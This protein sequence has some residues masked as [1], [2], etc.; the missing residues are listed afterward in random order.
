[1]AESLLVL[2]GS[3]PPRRRGRPAPL[4]NVVRA[5]LAEVEDFGRID[6]LSFDEVMVAS[7]AAADLAH[8]LSELMENA[9]NF[10]PPESRIEVVGHRTKADGYV[11][12]VTDHGIGMSGDQIASANESLAKPPLVGLAMTRSLGFIVVG[13]LA[14]RHGIAVRMMSS[15]S[16]GVTAV[17]SLA[18]SLVVDSPQGASTAV[19]SVEAPARLKPVLAQASTPITGPV[20]HR[21]K[22]TNGAAASENAAPLLAP[23]PSESTPPD[24]VD[25]PAPSVRV[26]SPPPA[27]ASDGD[28][29]LAW[30][31]PSSPDAPTPL[32]S[33]RPRATPTGPDESS[34]PEPDA[35]PEPL[36]GPLVAPR[37]LGG[38]APFPPEA[39]PAGVRPFFLEDAAV[40]SPSPSPSKPVS[41]SPEAPAAK[42]EPPRLFGGPAPEA[43][44]V[45]EPQVAIAAS[46]GV[47]SADT[48]SGR[49]D[50]EPVPPTAPESQ[51]TFEADLVREP[52]PIPVTTPM[53]GAQAPSRLPSRTSTGLAK[54]TPRAPGGGARAIPGADGERGRRCDQALARGDP[55][56]VVQPQRG[57]STGPFARSGT[58]WC[59]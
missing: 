15:A 24:A 8:L 58:C 48:G 27:V 19:P 2:A 9:A 51:P 10:S 33:R 7:N 43:P 36:P 45:V 34:A 11:I 26:D 21:S 23:V 49:E 6:L 32:A 57:S 55:G 46:D 52:D 44:V 41:S 14:A 37:S 39:E 47:H 50:A 29:P 56:H 35:L 16:G 59:L 3:E 40:A 53:A 4:G 42:A 30:S 17:V 28:G 22:A 1:M 25:L 54:R 38:P 31:A 18:P 13:R 5:A 20:P 12:S